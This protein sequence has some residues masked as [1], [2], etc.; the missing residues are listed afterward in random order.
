[1]YSNNDE[2]NQSWFSSYIIWVSERL[3]RI[4][5]SKHQMSMKWWTSIYVMNMCM[6]LHEV[7][8]TT[9][10][11][12]YLQKMKENVRS[13]ETVLIGNYESPDATA[14]NW[15]QV[16]C[17]YNKH[18]KPLIPLIHPSFNFKSHYISISFSFYNCDMN[19]VAKRS[20]YPQINGWS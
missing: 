18:F 6:F 4:N 3:G 9:Y 5:K 17:E 8:H 13:P 1:M 12:V 2:G 19:S 16:L 11:C 14:G 7:I 10:V 15:N 20:W